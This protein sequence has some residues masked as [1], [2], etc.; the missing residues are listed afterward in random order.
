MSVTLEDQEKRMPKTRRWTG[1]RSAVTAL[2]LVAWFAPDAGAA[3]MKTESI[4]S[5]MEYSTSGTIDSTGVTGTPV[6]SFNSAAGGSFTAPSSFS[7]GQFLVAA[8]P[9]GQTTTYTNTPF[10]ITYLANKVD[11][12]PTD[13]AT[14]VVVNGTLNGTIEG[15]SQS[16]VV[17]SFNSTAPLPFQTGRLQ[18]QLNV[19]DNPLSLVPSTTNGGRTTAQAQVIVNE[20][21]PPAIPEPTSVALFVTAIVGLGLRRRLRVAR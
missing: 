10:H 15:S 8:L 5:L 9:T 17:A 6:I 7:L 14:Q 19:L 4:K 11:G 1:L 20:V 2:A 13:P 21:V 16:N 3:A 18:N 12:L